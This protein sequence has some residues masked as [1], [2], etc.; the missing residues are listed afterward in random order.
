MEDHAYGMVA[1]E[2]LSINDGDDD[3]N[4][5]SVSHHQHHLHHHLPAVSVMVDAEDEVNIAQF[6]PFSGWCG[7]V[8]VGVGVSVV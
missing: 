7:L 5:V 1:S 4:A 2:V 3:L 6:H 8:G